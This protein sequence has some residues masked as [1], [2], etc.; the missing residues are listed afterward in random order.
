MGYTFIML[1]G[2]SDLQRKITNNKSF[3]QPIR[4]R[5]F[6]R[7]F[8]VN[9]WTKRFRNASLDKNFL[10]KESTAKAL[11]SGHTNANGNVKIQSL[12]AGS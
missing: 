4:M 10:I 9:G 1:K 12:S 6:G 5:K 11:L 2:E 3:L 8:T 7:F